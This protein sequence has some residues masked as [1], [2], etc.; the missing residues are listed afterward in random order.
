MTSCFRY[1]YDN[2]KRYYIVKIAN[3]TITTS[4]SHIEDGF[5]YI[6]DIKKYKK[7]LY[8]IYAIKDKKACVILSKYKKN[9][10]ESDQIK[11]KC[12]SVYSLDM[13][14]FKDKTKEMMYM[15]IKAIAYENYY[16]IWLP[17]DLYLDDIYECEQ[18]NGIYLIK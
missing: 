16:D 18:L 10:I 12:G 17:K 5:V 13:T 8:V 1:S 11:L 9:R 7:G 2:E 4:K 15:E 3:D 14:S 6:K